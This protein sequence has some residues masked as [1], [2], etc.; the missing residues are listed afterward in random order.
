MT[1]LLIRNVDDDDVHR[2][3]DLARRL[4][5]SRSELLRQELKGLAQ[6]AAVP[7]VTRENLERSTA[8]LDDAL[9]DEIMEQAW[10]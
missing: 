4:G 7:S 6:R 3:D 9:D 2:L 1:D 8:L 10:R 5:V